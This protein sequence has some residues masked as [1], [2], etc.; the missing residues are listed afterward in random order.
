ME[1]VRRSANTAPVK[2]N[3]PL[4]FRTLDLSLTPTDIVKSLLTSDISTWREFIGTNEDGAMKC[5]LF[6]MYSVE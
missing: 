5:S 1:N 6:S 2:E 4:I 3:L